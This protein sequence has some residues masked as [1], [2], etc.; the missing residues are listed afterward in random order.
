MGEKRNAYKIFVGKPEGNRS[1]GRPRLK[2]EDDIKMYLRQTGMDIVDWINLFQDRDRWRAL[3][4]TV[5]SL[6]IP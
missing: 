5:I 6:R 1:F 2:L 3:V 4:N